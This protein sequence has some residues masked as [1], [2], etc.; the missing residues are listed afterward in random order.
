MCPSHVFS[1]SELGTYFESTDVMSFLDK[2]EEPDGVILAYGPE[3]GARR[4]FCGAIELQ[5]Y[6]SVLPVP[7]SV[8]HDDSLIACDPIGPWQYTVLS[9]SPSAP[10]SYSPPAAP[11]NSLP[12]SAQWRSFKG[13]PSHTE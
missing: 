13:S 8:H 9:R 4:R 11:G 12:W 1:C 7:W 5:V 6:L 2:S 3:T 10:T